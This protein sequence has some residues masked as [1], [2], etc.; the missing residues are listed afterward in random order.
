MKDNYKR[1]LQ[2]ENFITTFT[3]AQYPFDTCIATT[4]YL[5]KFPEM[6]SKYHIQGILSR[7]LHKM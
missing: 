2:P 6:S 5:G 7:Q 4:L 1:L 3:P